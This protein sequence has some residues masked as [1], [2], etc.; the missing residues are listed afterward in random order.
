[1]ANKPKPIKQEDSNM[2][3]KYIYNQRQAQFYISNGILPLDVDIHMRT[4]CKFWVFD[5]QA[6]AVVYDMW[7]KHCVEYKKP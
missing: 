3:V 2:G 5:T 4:K 1:M 6:T 7:C